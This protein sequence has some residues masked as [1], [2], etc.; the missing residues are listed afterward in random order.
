VTDGVGPGADEAEGDEQEI[1]VPE[2][3]ARIAHGARLGP[4]IASLRPS[5]EAMGEHLV[6][7]V[8][9]YEL[10]I[11]AAR[12]GSQIVEMDALIA[13]C[14]DN[15][16]DLAERVA[17]SPWLPNRGSRAVADADELIGNGWP[18][19]FVHRQP[20]HDFGRSLFIV[21]RLV[22]SAIDHLRAIGILMQFDSVVRPPLALARITAEAA[23]RA[24]YLLDDQTS[25]TERMCRTLNA[26][27]EMLD[28]QRKA[29]KRE[30]NQEE[31]TQAT[32]EA[33]A[34]GR[35]AKEHGAV[36]S[37]DNHN[38]L[39]PYVR[40]GAMI[41]EVLQRE[42]S[43]TYHYLSGYVHSQEDKG[44]RLAMGLADGEGN[45]HQGM[46]LALHCFAG[47]LTFTEA[48]QRLSVFTGWD[49]SDADEAR[50]LVLELWARGAGMADDHYRQ[51]AEQQIAEQD[52]VNG[53]NA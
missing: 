2:F 20:G 47:L 14:A 27:L 26:E 28:E 50:D 41:D 32:E 1:D 5:R 6:N 19:D 21:R 43:S 24:C 49:L 42:H 4:I 7:L 33:T 23:A 40:P 34:I 11:S 13:E 9:L 16:T 17:W 18:R 52:C 22:E 8:N 35:I 3:L 38:Y 53:T 10:S 15:E 46:Y 30:A 25:T 12:L 39:E 48:C 45:P 44:W 29:A 37:R 31:V 51:V 36:R